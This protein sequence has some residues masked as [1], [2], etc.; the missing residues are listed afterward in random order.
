MKGELAATQRSIGKSMAP[1]GTTQS[2]QRTA[3]IAAWLF[4][5]LLALAASGMLALSA[6]VQQPACS[7]SQSAALSSPAAAYGANSVQAVSTHARTDGRVLDTGLATSA[8]GRMARHRSP[9]QTSA[10]VSSAKPRFSV[11]SADGQ[12]VNLRSAQAAAISV[13]DAACAGCLNSVGAERGS[14]TG[15]AGGTAPSFAFATRQPSS[16]AAASAGTA[17]T[18]GSVAM[19]SQTQATATM[20]SHMASGMAGGT[21][22]AVGFD[23][24]APASAASWS[25]TQNQR[26]TLER[27]HSAAFSGERPATWLLRGLMRA[28]LFLESRCAKTNSLHGA[29][30]TL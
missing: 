24:H 25:A 5:S 21:G 30:Q 10:G 12:R 23:G 26:A 13:S 16:S 29:S 28:P 11:L 6:H 7:V 27:V 15:T 1:T 19:P 8:Q 4:S 14:E 18:A 2:H 20:A 3:R 22:T 17:C 9:A